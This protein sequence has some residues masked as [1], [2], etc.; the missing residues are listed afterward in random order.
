M[1]WRARISLLR[2]G[3]LGSG[4]DIIVLFMCFVLISLDTIPDT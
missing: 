2:Y 1:G 3:S 4:D